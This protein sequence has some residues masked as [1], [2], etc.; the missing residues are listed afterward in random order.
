MKPPIPPNESE[1]LSTLRRYRV[2]DTAPE[3]PFD[4]LAAL[5]AEICR[6]PIAL[7]TL[8]DAERQWFKARVG[9]DVTQ[10]PRDLSFSAHAILSRHV[11][12]VGDAAIDPRFADNP[13]VLRGPR[14]R[15]YAGAPLITQDGAALGAL[16][17]L[18]FVPR[19]LSPAQIQALETLS[20]HV[21]GQL[22]FRLLLAESRKTEAELTSAKRAAEESNRA[23]SRFLA[24]MSHELRTPLN[25]IIGYSEMMEEHE[26]SKGD[27]A[28]VE[29][30]RKI[31][32]AGRHLLK[33]INEVLDLSKLEAGK[34]TLFVE[35]FDVRQMVYDAAETMRPLMRLNGIDFQAVCEEGVGSMEADLT[36]VRQCLFNL[37]G[38]AAKFTDHGQVRLNVSRR[39]TPQSESIEFQVS[40]TGIGMSP[41]QLAGLFEP[42]TQAEPAISRNYGGTGLGL[43]ITRQFC[44]LMGGDVAAASEAGKGS[45]FTMRLP[46]H[47]AAAAA[48]A[49]AVTAASL[50]TVP[51]PPDAGKT[52]LVIDDDDAARDLMMRHLQREGF[53]AV[54]ASSGPEGLRLAREIRPS[55]ITLDVV[56]P[57][58]DGWAVLAA[59]KAD[60]ELSVIPVIMLSMVDDRSMGYALGAAD[61]LVKPIER[62]RLAEML[63]A[64]K[65]EKADRPVLI[66][67]DDADTRELLRRTLGAEGWRVMEAED[68]RQ[69]LRCVMERRP[70]LILLDLMMPNM[71]GF[72]FVAELRKTESW[73]SIPIV[74]ITAQHLSDDDRNQLEG[75]VHKILRKVASTRE[76]LLDEV[77]RLMTRQL[78]PPG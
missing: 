47:T 12:V 69:A 40:D 17:V 59:L 50:P 30:L 28:S 49:A 4:D 41:E 9:T 14:F 71:N 54:A 72:E 33:L 34:A 56:M 18:D 70:A 46:A 66:V 73:R 65:T 37:L 52:V 29:D 10:T 20:R 22:D 27:Q 25:S 19:Q 67:E 5:A 76:E 21:V 64:Y 2:L 13:D 53:T 31:Q 8:V 58:M 77:G 38:N 61:Y 24:N 55:A 7:I 57:Q 32:G 15:F 78:K 35:R 75:S 68:G 44:W 16:C 39:R 48:V 42:F 1:R 36:K 74:V 26:L 45:T 63:D 23:K 51:V 6:A 11:M 60:P 43:A 62:G 3:R